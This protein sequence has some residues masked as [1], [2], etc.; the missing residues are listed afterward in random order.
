MKKKK[1]KTK[2]EYITRDLTPD[3]YSLVSSAYSDKHF[4]NQLEEKDRQHESIMKDIERKNKREQSKMYGEGFT[5]AYM[6]KD[7][8]FLT[9]EGLKYPIAQGTNQLDLL[10]NAKKNVLD[11]LRAGD[12]KY[13]WFFDD[14]T[15]KLKFELTKEYKEKEKPI[16]TLANYKDAGNKQLSLFRGKKDSDGEYIEKF[17]ADLNYYP[18]FEI[19]DDISEF[20]HPYMKEDLLEYVKDAR[21]GRKQIMKNQLKML[22]NPDKFIKLVK[23]QRANKQALTTSK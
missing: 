8:Y 20:K 18:K 4:K 16:I 10:K 7:D 1:E 23:K 13:E 12:K 15:N 2:Y 11:V 9:L 6:M 22:E 19:P 21:Q 5:D 14:D 17:K 3:F